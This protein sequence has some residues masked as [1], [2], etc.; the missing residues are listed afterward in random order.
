LALAFHRRNL[1]Q[2]SG[3]R[4]VQADRSLSS[5]DDLRLASPAGLFFLGIVGNTTV[6][7]L[8]GAE[9]L[10]GKAVEYCTSLRRHRHRLCRSTRARS[11]AC[12]FHHSPRTAPESRRGDGKEAEAS[13]TDHHR[14]VACIADSID[15]PIIGRR[16]A[17]LANATL[18]VCCRPTALT[19]SRAA[20]RS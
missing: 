7:V 17:R 9:G 11:S 10:A 19:A 12:A 18:G 6:K 2:A 3:A 4:S 14:T 8:R 5:P 20:G 16:S 1:R 13:S 15:S